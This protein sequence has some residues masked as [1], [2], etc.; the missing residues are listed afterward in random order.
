MRHKGREEGSSSEEPGGRRDCGEGPGPR[1]RPPAPRSLQPN[2]SL[3]SGQSL[4]SSQWKL[5][6]M[7]VFVDTQRNCVGPHTSSGRL[8]AGDRARWCGQQTLP[9]GRTTSIAYLCPT[10]C[11][12][13]LHQVSPA[14]FSH[15]IPMTTQL[16]GPGPDTAAVTLPTMSWSP[17]SH[18]KAI[19]HSVS[20]NRVISGMSVT[21]LPPHSAMREA[22]DPWSKAWPEWPASLDTK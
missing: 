15:L 12:G 11:P 13:H 9:S 7:H 20:Q 14:S 8:T 3:R 16:P 10:A 21:R 4:S 19:T 2:S 17:V 18:Q 1:A 5:A 22:Q 6:G